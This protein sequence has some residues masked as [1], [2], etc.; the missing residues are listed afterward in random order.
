MILLIILVPGLRLCWR[1]QG[2]VAA[3]ALPGGLLLLVI[4]PRNI[5]TPQCSYLLNHYVYR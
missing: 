4:P 5:I 2:Q 3:G 1:P